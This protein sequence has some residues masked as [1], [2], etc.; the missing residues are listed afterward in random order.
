MK[1]IKAFFYTKGHFGKRIREILD[2]ENKFLYSRGIYPTKIL[3]TDLPEYYC[4][5][6]SRSIW[7]MEGF[8]RTAGVKYIE[9]SFIDENHLFKDDYIY[10]SYSKPIRFETNPWGH[11]DYLDYD[12][13]ISG[14]DIIPLLFFIEKYSP[15]VETSHVRQKILKKY[16]LYREHYPE[17]FK[18]SFSDDTDIFE[19]YKQFMDYHIIKR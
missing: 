18:R 6:H 15:D 4:K 14:N 9:Y 19:Y 5:I 3:E 1:K 7:Y 12:I 11:L 8:V 17:D 13:C 16:Q 2:T 10:I